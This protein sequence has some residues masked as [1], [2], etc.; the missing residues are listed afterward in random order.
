GAKRIDA[1]T[2]YSGTPEQERFKDNDAGQALIVDI[3]QPGAEPAVTRH[4]TGQYPW[5]QRHDSMTGAS[6]MQRLVRELAELADNS[7]IDLTV[8]GRIDLAAY[9]QLK[10]ELGR[11]AA[12]HRSFQTHLDG[13]QLHPTDEDIANLQ[14]DGYL[15]DVIDALRE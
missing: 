7:V 10:H 5:Q 4:A 9:Q 11:A 13:L 3:D 2:W 14:A 6:D 12:R 15:S 8:D 1:R